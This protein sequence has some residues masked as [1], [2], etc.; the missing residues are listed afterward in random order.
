M[1]GL[2]GAKDALDD[3]LSGGLEGG[4]AASVACSF[5]VGVGSLF[6]NFEPIC[7]SH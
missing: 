4:C 3:L 6:D 5:V 7:S 1:M 2:F